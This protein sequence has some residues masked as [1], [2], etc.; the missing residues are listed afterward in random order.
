[1]GFKEEI[2]VNAYQ[3]ITLNQYFCAAPLLNL[4]DTQRPA[5]LNNSGTRKEKIPTQHPLIS[6]R[7]KKSKNQHI[8]KQLPPIST[9]NEERWKQKQINQSKTDRSNHRRIPGGDTNNQKVKRQKTKNT[10]RAK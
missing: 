3:S 8:T 2:L 9:A 1:M 4:E 5:L 7:N 10:T 6:I